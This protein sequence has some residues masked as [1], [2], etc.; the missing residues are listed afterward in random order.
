MK[1]LHDV[2]N[3]FKP[4]LTAHQLQS[5][6]DGLM[7]GIEIRIWVGQKTVI[8]RLAQWG[9][10]WDQFHYWGWDRRQIETRERRGRAAVEA[11]QIPIH[12]TPAAKRRLGV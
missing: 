3:A 7:Q 12:F 2:R 8:Q 5:I 4:R 1:H 11:D 9:R 6:G 10:W